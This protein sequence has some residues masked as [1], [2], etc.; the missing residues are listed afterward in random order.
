MKLYT[1]LNYYKETHIK[2]HENLYKKLLDEIDFSHKRAKAEKHK[3]E[4]ISL[5]FIV[6]F[7]I[8]QAK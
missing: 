2:G 8:L 5:P 3:K 4:E 1:C 7:V 6:F